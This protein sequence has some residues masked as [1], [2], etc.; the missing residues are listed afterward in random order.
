MVQILFYRSLSISDFKW[1]SC[2]STADIHNIASFVQNQTGAARVPQSLNKFI[3]SSYSC[4]KSLSR[5]GCSYSSSRIPGSKFRKEEYSGP[6]EPP[7]FP[8]TE[9]LKWFELLE[10][11]CQFYQLQENSLKLGL[12][13]AAKSGAAVVML[14][15]KKQFLCIWQVLTLLASRF[16]SLIVLANSLSLI[17]CRQSMIQL[18]GQISCCVIST[19]CWYYQFKKGHTRLLWKEWVTG[20]ST[21]W[22]R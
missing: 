12:V 14:C 22:F 6:K 8:T 15:L 11:L 17:I 20:Y 4:S 18:G 10:I 9:G 5:T 2:K 13:S 1:G 7:L 21:R 16:L 19:S 3:A